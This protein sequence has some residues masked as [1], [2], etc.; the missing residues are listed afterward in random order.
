MRKDQRG[1]TIVEL[2][3]AVAI[4]AIVVA[5]VCG[6]ILVGS[7]SYAAG[8]SDISVQQ[9]AQLALN[10]M[11][12]VVIDTT[13]S[14][15]YIGYDASGSNVEKKLKDAEFSFT[16]EDKSLVMYNGVLVKN[17][18]GGPDTIE[19][20]NGNK[21]YNFYWDKS[22]ETLFY[23]EVDA[24]T[25][26]APIFG[27]TSFEW[28]VLASHVT[29]FSV[30]LSQVEE[31]RV[32]QLALTFVDGVK[33]YVTSNN[34]TI[35][36]KVGVNDAELEAI[37]KKKTLMVT[38]RDNP[39]IEPGET[40][41][42]STPKVT[43]ENVTDRSVTW[44]L[45]PSADLSSGTVFTDTT[46]GILKVAED[47][48][49]GVI[50]V[51]ITTNAVDSDGNHAS[52]TVPVHIKRVYP[53]GTGVV[54]SKTADT[55]A[56]NG[57][58]EISPGCTFTITATVSGYKL[59][60]VCSVCGDDVTM[61]KQVSYAG[62]PYG[63]P[64]PWRIYD[65][66]SV[67][68]ATTQWNPNEFIDILE[69]EPDHA[70]FYMHDDAP[71]STND[72]T[73]GVV[74]QAMSTLSTQPNP[75]FGR[76]YDRWVPGAI[77]FRMVKNKESAEP[78]K[79]K[80]KYGVNDLHEDVR[81]G[82]PTDYS[83]YV[84]A[85]RVKDNS[86]KE[87]DK[88]VLHY[89]T[90]GG[91]NY[92]ISP[93]L[94]D[95]DLDG[96]YTFYMQAIFPIPEDRYKGDGSGGVPDDNATIWKEYYDN[97]QGHT[98]SEGYT[99]TKYRHGKVFYAKL[100]RPKLTYSYKGVEYT[101]K[102]IFYDPV[103]IYTV[104]LGSGIVGEI[105]PT[106][107][108]NIVE[109]NSIWNKIANSLYEGEGDNL[110]GWNKIYYADKDAVVITK[111][112]KGN[113]SYSFNYHGKNTLADGAVQIDPRGS[114]F[115]KLNST[116]HAEKACG[117]YHIVPGMVYKNNDPGCFEIIGYAGFDFPNLKR[118]ARYYEF[119]DST[120]HVRIT[121][122]FTMDINHPDFKGKAMFPL[123][124]EMKRNPL[125]MNME[126]MEWQTTPA[127]LTVKA[128][129]DGNSWTED[130]TFIYVRYRYIKS[131]NT[132][133]VEPVR[134]EYSKDTKKIRV[135][136]Y[137][138]YKCGEND[139]KWW[140]YKAGNT[141]EKEFTIRQFDFNGSTYLADFPLPMDSDF[142]FADGTGEIERTLELFDSNM[143]QAQNVP[144]FMVS[145]KKNGDAYEI[146]FRTEVKDNP[147]DSNNHKIKV[148]YYGT[149]TWH[150]GQTEWT[151]TKGNSVSYKTDLVTNLEGLSIGDKSYRMYFPLPSE[152]KFPF[153][154]SGEKISCTSEYV[155]Y[156]VTDL[157]AE[158]PIELQY[159]YDMKYERNG[160]THRITFVNRYNE[161]TEYGTFECANGE[162]MWRKVN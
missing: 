73:Y 90:G 21:N 98:A 137:G 43:G 89:T 141:T 126:S 117:S 56:D 149:Y 23:A 18:S 153:K 61:D 161:G 78:Y 88:I 28:V 132:W 50:E 131:E 34:V 67:G 19:E 68:G 11:S 82:L 20:G 12:D 97:I 123:P 129:R 140:C 130:L 1:F 63:N 45:Q 4:L 91:N 87:P 15:N 3:I 36:N 160:N 125:F 70:T 55:N 148:N 37:N 59:G 81:A 7:R 108:E 5:S 144:T 113:E 71:T 35:R 100:D 95:L 154:N 8:N 121:D 80:L 127:K 76:Q 29:D 92:R 62:N 48:K 74:I 32:V 102:N 143:N 122:Q 138:I 13:R 69:S 156:A 162:T 41:H 86:G 14:V 64:Y 134:Y 72:V 118:E 109:D 25:G 24:T 142:P 85:V 52:C 79:G 6:F 10:Q 112:E 151:R 51:A 159:N 27:D 114:M 147:Y 94:F 58:N 104:G 157:Y 103:N 111:D 54:L 49:A 47:Q 9:E 116:N 66:S 124:K 93:D 136:S 150:A 30:D 46:N 96:S 101:G 139:E 39:I 31:K 128:R 84:T 53:E 133:E 44:S 75:V 119:D 83:K 110:S 2:L 158:K 146:E 106:R 38:P 135:H 105:R 120:I 60:E 152:S 65:P 99:G 40:Y 26:L 22:E 16:P 77:E 17:P 155:A 115:L 33:E 107:Y 42:F 57:A 145:C